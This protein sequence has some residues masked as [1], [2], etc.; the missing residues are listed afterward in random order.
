LKIALT[1]KFGYNIPYMKVVFIN[2][3][4]PPYAVGGAEQVVAARAAELVSAGEEAV[5]ISWRPWQGWGSW[6]PQKGVENGIIIYRYWVPNIFSYTNLAK[7]NFFW[8]ILWHKLDVWNCWSGRIV[9]KILQQENP[10]KVET[11]NLMGVGFT[12]PKLIQ[13]LGIKHV[14]VLHDVQLVEL[15]GVLAW[16][17]EKDNLIQKI[18]A[19]LMKR[20][21]GQP[22]V[23]ITHSKFLHNFYE[24]RNFFVNAEWQVAEHQVTADLKSLTTLPKFLFVG[25]LVKHK[26][27]ELLMEAWAKLGEVANELHIV[28]D[29]SLFAKVEEW[30]EDK[31]QVFV[32][33]RLES[34]DLNKLYED[35]DFLIFPSICLENKPLS[36]IEA[37]EYGLH[38]I[39]ADTGGVHEF[40][41]EKDNT[42]LFRP[43]D[44]GE[45][46]KKIRRFI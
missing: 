25:S 12:I 33:G 29:G 44:V 18:Y 39:A 43:G 17:H 19:W 38:V 5:V 2:N 20:K 27:I 28:G 14:H 45:L 15:S 26:G 36:I 10:D 34:A 21:F 35:C 3:L 31:G 6:R 42:W 37:L 13:K 32:H 23:I 40:V 30:G 11:H 7:H 9:K 41:R 24:E 22:D 4:F 46:V 1:A 8:K 16:N